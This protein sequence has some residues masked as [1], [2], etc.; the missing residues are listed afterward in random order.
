MA[1][2]SIPIPLKDLLSKLHFLGC[3][4]R[5][6]K[7]NMSDKSFSDASSWFAAIKRSF[8]GEGRDTMIADINRI[9]EETIHAIDHY[10]ET[11]F[12][13]LLIEYLEKAKI[14]IQNLTATYQDDPNIISQLTVAIENVN[15]Q[16][17]THKKQK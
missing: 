13:P 9:I 17:K 14:G 8:S 12:L 11:D 15:I 10:A 16:L 4:Q 3:I 1:S 6:S 7:I 5:G 2:N